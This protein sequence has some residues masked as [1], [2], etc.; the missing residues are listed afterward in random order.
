MD[1]EFW[2]LQRQYN[3]C[4]CCGK[5]WHQA[6]LVARDHIIPVSRGG[7]NQALNLQPLCQACNLWKLDA[8]IHF[9]PAFPGRPAALPARLHEIA[10]RLGLLAEPELEAE[11]LSFGP[12]GSP[13][14]W[15]YPAAT[16]QQLEQQTLILTRQARDLPL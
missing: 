6:G 14:V 7:P 11:Q 16:P 5:S 15:N 3:R 13:P 8:V 9:D 10:E 2:Q 12:I 4:P 1:A